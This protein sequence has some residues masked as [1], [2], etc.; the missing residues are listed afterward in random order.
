MTGIN[1]YDLRKDPTYNREEANEIW[2]IA[3]NLEAGIEFP[4]DYSYLRGQ[5]AIQEK[6]WTYN[7]IMYAGKKATISPLCIDIAFVQFFR[8]LSEPLDVLTAQEI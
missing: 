8:R 1:C 6:R 4:G 7:E 3:T 5:R 2:R